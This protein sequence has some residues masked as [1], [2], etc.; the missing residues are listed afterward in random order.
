MSGVFHAAVE[1]AASDVSCLRFRLI[2][3]LLSDLFMCVSGAAFL[4]QLL[5]RLA[6]RRVRRT[7]GARAR[8]GGRRQHG[9]RGAVLR[10]LPAPLDIW[11]ASK[12]YAVLCR[13]LRAR[14]NSF[15][16][17]IFFVRR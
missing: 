12:Q 15:I 17:L 4:L 5:E 11:S 3:S 10:T 1:R 2:I 9:S 16:W 8:N 13:C 14:N 6:A 7:V